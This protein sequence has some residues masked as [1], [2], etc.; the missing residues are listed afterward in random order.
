MCAKVF[1]AQFQ[2]GEDFVGGFAINLV[3]VPQSANLPHGD[4][5]AIQLACF[6][7]IQEQPAL[8]AVGILG[9]GKGVARGAVFKRATGLRGLFGDLD[10]VLENE[11][12]EDREA[13]KGDK[14]A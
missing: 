11:V 1:G 5:N 13:H 14:Y 9:F 12:R 7:A 4:A 10:D 6:L 8:R 2:L 3:T